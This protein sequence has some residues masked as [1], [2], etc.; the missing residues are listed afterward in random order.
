MA[1]D[2]PLNSPRDSSHLMTWL[3]EQRRA[4]RAGL[5]DLTR[6]VELLRAELREQAM[7]LSRL[8]GGGAG[9]GAADGRIVQ[10]TLTQLK[11]HIALIERALE[12]HF[13]ENSRAQQVETAQS[14]RET[15]QI[16]VVLQ[17]VEELGRA[18][19]A[20]QGRIA[21]LSE[22]LRHE[23]QER[24]PIG[25][26]LEN[27]QRTFASLQNRLLIV[28]DQSRRYASYQGATEQAL[29]VQRGDLTRFEQQQ[30]LLDL[31]VSRDVVDIQ[32]NVTAIQAR[33]DD[34]LKPISGLIRQ[35]GTIEDRLE[36][37]EQSL[38]MAAK[39]VDAIRVEIGQ[40]DAQVKTE[41]VSNSRLRGEI[42]AQ[43]HRIE[44]EKG[45]IEQLGE[46]LNGVGSNVQDLRSVIELVNGRIDRIER[47]LGHIEE[48]RQQFDSALSA[49]QSTLRAHEN[50]IRVQASEI[51]SELGNAT[52][53][54][55][56][57]LDADR[58]TLV[59]HRR[60]TVAELQQQLGDLDK[61]GN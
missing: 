57:R 54:L 30:K 28:E 29:E 55:W 27:L 52:A 17:Q 8:T 39:S 2:V 16:G 61:G 60:R 10:E 19:Q 32:Q 5:G 14:E 41:R 15:R 38:A 11:E 58:R 48:V 12:D 4:D 25:Q 49:L 37:S 31:R 36:R 13:D 53:E 47:E 33:V 56:R 7:T 51:R 46:R 50:E 1:A 22:E 24:G 43:S 26:S 34:Q 18:T 45:A 59:E 6:S 42:E 35:L 44:E 23:R 20:S 3:E 40:V 9:Q 21:A